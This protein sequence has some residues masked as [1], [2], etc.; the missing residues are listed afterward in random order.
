M[1]MLARSLFE[2]RRKFLLEKMS[3]RRSYTLLSPNT[4][5]G[6]HRT[7]AQNSGPARQQCQAACFKMC[8]NNPKQMIV[9]LQTSNTVWP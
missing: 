8:H 2:C 1:N 3:L 7:F 9:H 5:K 6:P 4:T